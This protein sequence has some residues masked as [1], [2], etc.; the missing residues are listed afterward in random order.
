MAKNKRA[1]VKRNNLKSL[2]AYLKVSSVGDEKTWDF[3]GLRGIDIEKNIINDYDLSEDLINIIQRV[4]KHLLEMF[5]Q[6]FNREISD[7]GTRK[8]RFRQS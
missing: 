8:L 1:K 3:S 2:Y 5:I 4:K 6:P 7:Y